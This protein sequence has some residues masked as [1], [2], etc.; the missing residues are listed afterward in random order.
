MSI[1]SKLNNEALKMLPLM[2]KAINEAN[3][4]EYNQMYSSAIRQILNLNPCLDDM[5]E[6]EVRRFDQ[7]TIDGWKRM[8]WIND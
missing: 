8:G 4:F 5:T 2:H 3:G 1:Q 7:E 6:E